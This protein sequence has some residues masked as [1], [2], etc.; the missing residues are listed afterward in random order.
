M[1]FEGRMRTMA[2]DRVRYALAHGEWPR[3]R[4]E[5]E[6]GAPVDKPRRARSPGRRGGL[7]AEKARDQAALDALE[8]GALRLAR[9][10]EAVGGERCNVLRRLVK[11]AAQGLVEP[12]PRCCPDRG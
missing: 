3:G 7:R 1:R 10:A 12:P 6:D 2:A 8:C 9:V 11:L 5:V 4:V